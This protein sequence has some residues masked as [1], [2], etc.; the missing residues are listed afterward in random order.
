MLAR[1]GSTLRDFAAIAAIALGGLGLAGCG[2]GGGGGGGTDAVGS[3]G[4]GNASPTAG[5]SGG[6]SYLPQLSADGRIVAFAATASDLV[7]SDTNAVSDVFV[8]D[9]AAG[10]TERVSVGP[11]GT[12]ANGPSYAPSIT[13]DGLVVVFES[14]AS[15]LVQQDMNGHRDV[16]AYDRVQKRAILVSVGASGGMALGTSG[17]ARVS[18]D[19]RLV[20]FESDATNLVPDDTN[21][22]KDVFV[23]DL[24]AG[25]TRRVSVDSAG[26]Q[27]DRPS[28]RPTIS[29]DGTRVA[30]R[31]AATRLLPVGATGEQTFLHDLATGTTVCV[32]TPN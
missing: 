20:V 25:T 10:S 12:Q 28:E 21:A 17:A 7:A 24:A 8:R 16:F 26:T 19:G 23:R 14:D 22:M 11:A 15:N 9:V 18:A 2:G 29:A 1:S 3:G 13:A 4:G 30:F 27:L 31:S 32:S 5:R 6:G